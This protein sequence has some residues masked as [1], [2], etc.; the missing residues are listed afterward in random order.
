MGNSVNVVL[1]AFTLMSLGRRKVSTAHLVC[2]A[3]IDGSTLWHFAPSDQ[4]PLVETVPY[5][6]A[7][8]I[9]TFDG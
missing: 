7:C 3:G 6:G 4:K 2:I 5:D 8:T 1:S 9:T